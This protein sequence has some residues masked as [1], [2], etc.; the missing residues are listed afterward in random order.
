MDE[1]P[2]A[3]GKACRGAAS[4]GKRHLI[5]AIDLSITTDDLPSR[6]NMQRMRYS[7]SSF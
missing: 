3:I 7:V 6:R 2:E 1:I 5:S 4:N